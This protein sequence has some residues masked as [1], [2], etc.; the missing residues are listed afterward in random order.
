M[1]KRHTTRDRSSF[2]GNANAQAHQD[3]WRQFDLETQ[4]AVWHLSR[5]GLLH[6]DIAGMSGIHLSTVKEIIRGIAALHDGPI[7]ISQKVRCS[8][9]GALLFEIPCRLCGWTTE[10]YTIPNRGTA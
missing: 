8:S 3:R 6:S 10:R 7:A 4:F 9:C 1:S 2:A 5:G